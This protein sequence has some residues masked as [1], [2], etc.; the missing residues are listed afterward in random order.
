[1]KT[2]QFGKNRPQLFLMPVCLVDDHPLMLPD[3]NKNH[4]LIVFLVKTFIPD[5]PCF[6]ARGSSNSRCYKKVRVAVISFTF[7]NKNQYLLFTVQSTKFLVS[8]SWGRLSK[9]ITFSSD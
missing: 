9:K 1:M 4:I 2:F 8:V 7:F 6:Q 3:E 5:M